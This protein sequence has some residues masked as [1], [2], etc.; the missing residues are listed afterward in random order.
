MLDPAYVRDH[1]DAVRAG[2][3]SRGLEPDAE[4]EQVATLETRRRRLIPE[5]EGLKREQNTAGDEVA[6][7][8][9]QGKD[10]SDIFA[11]N[12]ARAQ[13]IRQLE[14]QLE[15]VE[16][17]RSALLM[18]LPN[19]PHGSVPLG[20]S[21]EEN[22][23]VRRIGEPRPFD[24][25]PRPHWD[26]G[27]ALGILDFERA[28]RMSGS[29][30]SV[31]LGPGARLARA[32]INFM[33]DIHTREHG[34]LEVE[35]PFL[36]NADALRGTAQLPKFEQDLFKVAGEWDLYL[37]PTA[38]VPL[39]NL[40]RGEILDGRLLPLRYT[41]YTPCFRS[42]AGSYGADVRG[43]I[44]Q[45]QFDKVELVKFTTPE[46][47]YDELEALTRNAEVILQRLGLPYRTMLLCSGDTGFASAKTYD[48]EV[49]L[50]SQKMYREISSCSN[51]EAFQAR[52]ANIKFRAV[53]GKAEFAH[54]LNGSGL[55][56][57]RTLIAV[58]ENYQQ[59]DG[60]VIVPEPLRP[61]MGGMELIE[62][63]TAEV[64]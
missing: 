23:E 14:V 38:E 44:R 4:L 56:V 36:V 5:V 11:A 35:P 27:V 3:R 53:G 32:L 8:K 21:A 43:L 7:A 17:Q 57:G 58:L 1:M 12:K 6:R 60:S 50:P 34:Y 39:T 52:R 9:R 20:K 25:E 26:L 62:P 47:S 22:V 10:A 64:R 40:H 29:R 42:E 16:Q 18:T 13:Q 51:T 59:A 45:H 49:W 63:R 37:I 2:L 19:L 33:L 54:T 24:F 41:A 46:Q 48:I 31:L 61:Y 30:F 15:Q 28:T 55:A